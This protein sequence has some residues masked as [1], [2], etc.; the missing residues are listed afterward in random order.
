MICPAAQL[1]SD[2]LELMGRGKRQQLRKATHCKP[3]PSTP[4]LVYAELAANLR[5]SRHPEVANI[6]STMLA[7]LKLSTCVTAGSTIWP[8]VQ[9]WTTFISFYQPQQASV[10]QQCQFQLAR[11]YADP[12]DPQLEERREQ[13]LTAAWN[14]G[15]WVNPN[16]S[17]VTN[18]LAV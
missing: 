9:Y 7:L 4:I 11:Y 17:N 14:Y 13:A 10:K 18:Y 2:A 6:C 16:P 8:S 5:Y 12:K 15:M 3:T 1:Y